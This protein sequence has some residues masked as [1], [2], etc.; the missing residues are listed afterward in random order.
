MPKHGWKWRT[1]QI[2]H[3]DDNELIDLLRFGRFSGKLSKWIYRNLPNHEIEALKAIALSDAPW[4]HDFL[5]RE[6]QR[7]KADAL[8]DW[9]V[10]ALCSGS[11]TGPQDAARYLDL[12]DDES[13]HAM[14]RGS[15]IFGLNTA[16]TNASMQ[17][18]KTSVDPISKD[19]FLRV[20]DACHR[21]IHDS[22]NPYARA[23]ACWLGASLGG[24]D[25]ELAQLRNDHTPISP[26]ESLTVASHYEAPN[27][28]GEIF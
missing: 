28:E 3:L 12:Y 19:I 13:A 15:A 7:H 1:E 23:G 2:R 11:M 5:W 10:I 21:A 17:K 16:I 6:L 27:S 8:G 26:N 22:N 9:V 4:A 14:T 18:D 25:D 24:F 20:R